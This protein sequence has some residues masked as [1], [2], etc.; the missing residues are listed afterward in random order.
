[1]YVKRMITN[2]PLDKL[3]DGGLESGII[4]NIYGPP[5][6]GKTNFC[7]A[8]LIQA[9]NRVLYMD[10]EGSFSLD[11]FR[12]LGGDE[13]KLKNVI[14]IDVHSWK[15]QYEQTLKIDK[16]FQKEKID[17]VVVDSLVALY[18]LELDPTDVKIF[19]TLNRQL[20]T[21]YAILSK[22]ARQ[23][24]IP[25]LVTN[26]VYGSGDDV[27]PTSKAITRYWSKCLIELKKLEKENCRR[28]IV[29]KHRSVP[30]NKYVDFEIWQKG[31]REVKKFF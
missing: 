19:T 12:Q 1:M 9:K 13:R 3:L 23:N 14:F 22:I 4:T 11:R 24:N 29:K 30:E 5:G 2:T 17:L 8:S 28:A 31:L 27:E 10:S 18:R 15:D 21:I 20:A 6:C 26:Q 16:F 7:L 25:I